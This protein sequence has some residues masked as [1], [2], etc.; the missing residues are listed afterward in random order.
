[1]TL[2]TETAEYLLANSLSEHHKEQS[3]NSTLASVANALGE[4]RSFY[5]TGQE[6]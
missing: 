4:E 2:E 3:I 5:L 6:N 1:M